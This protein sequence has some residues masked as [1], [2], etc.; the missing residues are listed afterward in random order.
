MKQT[1]IAIVHRTLDNSKTSLVIG[2][3]VLGTAFTILAIG[4]LCWCLWLRYQTIVQKEHTT[5]RSC[6]KCQ[7]SCR[8]SEGAGLVPKTKTSSLSL[9]KKRKRRSKQ[10]AAQDNAASRKS[11][12]RTN[13]SRGR[14]RS[15]RASRR[16]GQTRSKTSARRRF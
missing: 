1:L 12:R 8:C 13:A 6:L 11:S 16:K 10:T 14:R 15:S 3:I 9:K 5:V 2:I 4:V 7:G